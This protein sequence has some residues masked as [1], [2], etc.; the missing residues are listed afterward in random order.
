MIIVYAAEAAEWEVKMKLKNLAKKLMAV[1][2]STVLL[3]GCGGGNAPKNT[4]STPADNATAV[5]GESSSGASKAEGNTA[6]GFEKMKIAVAVNST[7][8]DFLRTKNAFES[9]IGPALNIE[10]MFSEAISD[11]GALTTFIENAY[12]SGCNAV[13]T[14][15]S[16]SIDQAAAVCNDLGMYFVGINSAG[17]SENQSLPYYVSVCGASSEGYGASYA[18]ALE[19][20]ISDG[21]EH[22][23]LIL[24]GAACYGATSYIEGTA[25]SLRAMQDVYGLTY[26]QDIS[27]LATTTTQIEAENDKEIKITIVPGMQ[28]LANMVSPL[29]QTGDYDIVVGTTD[30]Y[31]SLS[32]AIN[33]VEV[34]LGTNIHMISRNTFTE[35]MATAFNTNDSAGTPIIDGMIDTGMYETVAAVILLRNSYDG[36]ADNMRDN[37][38]CSRVSGQRPMV[39]TTPDQY[40]KLTAEGVPYAF[41]TTDEILSLCSVKNPSVTWKDISDFGEAMTTEVVMEKLSK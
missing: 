30:I 22:S 4:S 31:G 10:F 23:V 15:V 13:Y 3:T 27:T 38:Q 12:A 20:I 28:D 18:E 34:A 29:L 36:Y 35:M 37:G 39:V 9:T 7:K 41:M 19:H 32:V 25:G 26:T 16:S 5:S 33:E 21:Q 8:D 14:N 40:N 11:A 24:S 6:V 17:A 1:M 2:L